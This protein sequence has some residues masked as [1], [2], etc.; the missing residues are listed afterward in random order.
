[1]EEAAAMLFDPTVAPPE[2]GAESAARGSGLGAAKQNDFAGANDAGQ[3]G[4]DKRAR[5]QS[6]EI[7][8]G[9]VVEAKANK[10]SLGTTTAA[11]VT[12][13]AQHTPSTVHLAVYKTHDAASHV[14][15][16]VGGA[17]G[18]VRN[19]I[20]TKLVERGQVG[21]ASVDS[22]PAEDFVRVTGALSKS[23]LHHVSNDWARL[24]VSSKRTTART[25]AAARVLLEGDEHL[26]GL[27]ITVTPEAKANTLKITEEA[28]MT[29][30]RGMIVQM[31]D[32][33]YK[34]LLPSTVRPPGHPNL[35]GVKGNAALELG[36]KRH[37]HIQSVVVVKS[38]LAQEA[39][40]RDQI[41]A[42]RRASGETRIDREQKI[43]NVR[44]KLTID[45]MKKMF[46]ELDYDDSSTRMNI[47]INV[48][49]MVDE[50]DLM[51][52]TAK[53]LD[54]PHFVNASFVVDDEGIER[55]RRCAQTT[56]HAIL[57]AWPF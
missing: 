16:L 32:T 35:Q 46:S 9:V 23:Q 41:A 54:E 40:S 47:K 2:A 53:D 13:L 24:L 19:D 43:R 5:S 56:P 4:A 49:E 57:N 55:V 36:E 26:V 42:A 25:P 30:V 52:Y 27:S 17:A 18:D 12:P 28:Q 10:S 50:R 11:F 39:I 45:A 38:T 22:I 20:Y 21:D 6:L 48:F 51:S 34:P 44:E 1:M 8:Y 15:R 31:E 7:M 14:A 33:I 3:S 37:A 29:M